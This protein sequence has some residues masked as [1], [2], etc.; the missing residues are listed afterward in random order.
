MAVISATSPR[1]AR[2][3]R[4]LIAK[5]LLYAKDTAHHVTQPRVDEDGSEF[6]GSSVLP[7][8]LVDGAMSTL[9]AGFS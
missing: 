3:P 9:A 7:R 1:D 4:G 6:G 5:M 2:A 8:R